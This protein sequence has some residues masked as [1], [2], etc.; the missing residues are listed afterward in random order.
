VEDNLNDATADECMQETRNRLSD[1]K[2]AITQA[3]HTY[4]HYYDL[5]R[6]SI[7]KYKVGGFVSIRLHKHP[8]SI[9]KASKLAQ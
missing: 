7:P 9:I 4:K 3:F 8:V 2:E 1:A 5:N 6:S